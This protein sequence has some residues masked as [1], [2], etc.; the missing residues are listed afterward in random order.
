MNEYLI[1]IQE[2]RK[3]FQLPIHPT[4][5]IANSVNEDRRQ[6]AIDLIAEELE[7]LEI[8][9][10]SKDIEGVA[11]ALVDLQYVLSQAVFEF[12]LQQEFD[13]LFNEVHRS[14]MTKLDSDGLPIYNRAGK[15]MK[16]PNYE[17]PDF[18]VILGL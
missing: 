13:S 12:G 1:K 3:A 10:Q 11:D 4:Y 17:P 8:S 14:N 6:L 9:M 2:F 5:R 7:E 18:S 15:V 16:G